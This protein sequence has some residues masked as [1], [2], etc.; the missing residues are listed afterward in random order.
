M[1]RAWPSGSRA[2]DHDS[3]H[4]KESRA[5]RRRTGW[6]RGPCRQAPLGTTSR[7][8]QS[9]GT[10]ERR[11]RHAESAGG[12]ARRRKPTA[13]LVCRWAAA[14]RSTVYIEHCTGTSSRKGQDTATLPDTIDSSGTRT[15]TCSAHAGGRQPHGISAYADST[16]HQGPPV[17]GSHQQLSTQSRCSAPKGTKCSWNL[18]PKQRVLGTSLHWILEPIGTTEKVG[19]AALTPLQRPD[20]HT[21]FFESWFLLVHARGWNELGIDLSQLHRLYGKAYT[22]GYRVYII[23][24]VPCRLYKQHQGCTPLLEYMWARDPQTLYSIPS[25]YAQT[26]N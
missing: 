3:H 6:P 16:N 17:T 8:Q 25:P 15:L 12:T 21:R 19:R 5:T 1:T 4:M 10:T 26:S 23:L 20:G 7:T 24:R 13:G 2:V 18:W 9:A 11:G 14:G 22:H